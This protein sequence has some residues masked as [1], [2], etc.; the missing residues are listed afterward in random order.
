MLLVRKVLWHSRRAQHKEAGGE[1]SVTR[2][3]RGVIGDTC[4]AK[5]LAMPDESPDCMTNANGAQ[6]LR[7]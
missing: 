1:P 5:A 3:T 4:D 7:R 6:L 2:G